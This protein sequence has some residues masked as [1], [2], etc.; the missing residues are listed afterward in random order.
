MGRTVLSAPL[1]EQ[2]LARLDHLIHEVTQLSDGQKDLLLEHLQ[3]ARTYLLG[4]M[5]DEYELNLGAA[6]EAAAGITDARLQSLVIQEVT[7]LQEGTADLE[8]ATAQGWHRPRRVHNSEPADADKGELYR[9]FHGYKTKLGVFYPTKYIFAAF[10]SFRIACDAAGKL[11]AAGFTKDEVVAVTDAETSRFFDEMRADAGPWGELMA[12]FSRFLGTEEV[13]AD[14]DIAE[15]RQGAGF[16][17]VY[18][19]EEEEAE[20][21]RNL[22]GPLGPLSMQLYLPDGVRSLWAG[23]SPGPQGHH[24]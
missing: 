23:N 1:R 18:C 9:F 16:L 19:P 17:A 22:L 7:A 11:E 13:F 15:S 20:R 6:K 8:P 21:I 3:G 12:S 5:P 24:P 10:P 2:A 4:A 14:I